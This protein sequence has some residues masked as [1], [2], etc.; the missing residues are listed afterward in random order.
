MCLRDCVSCTEA[1]QN[2]ELK[3]TP[4]APN[5]FTRHLKVSLVDRHSAPIRNLRYAF[6][7]DISGC[8]SP[9]ANQF[10]LPV[11]LSFGGLGW[12]VRL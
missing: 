7:L 8:P 3:R 6:L 10:D 5:Q 4:A 9:T 1:T 11:N 2:L 12:L